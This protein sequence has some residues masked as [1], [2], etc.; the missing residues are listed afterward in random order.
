MKLSK[1]FENIWMPFTAWED[2]LNYPPLIIERAKGI[3]IYDSQSHSYIDGIGSWWTKI[4]GHNHP[5]ITDAV[6]N[7][8]SKLEHV[9]MAGCISD[10]TLKLGELLKQ[11]LPKELTKIFFSDDGSTAVEVALK[12]AL[13][14]H[15]LNGEK[16]KKKFIGL[17][18]GYHGDTLGAM[19]VGSIPKYHAIFHKSFKK[20]LFTDQIDCYRCKYGKKRN[21]CSAECL[22]SLEILLKKNQEEIAA[23]IFEPLLQG[24]CGMRVYPVGALEKIFYLCQ[25]YKVLT[26]ADEVATGFGRTGKMFACQYTQF[27]PDIM[28]IGKCLTSGYLPMAA[29]IV[30]EFIFDIFKGDFLSGRTFEHGHTF[31]GN[32]LASAA[33]I[34]TIELIKKYKIPQSLASLSLKLSELLNEFYR[35]PQVGEVRTLG[36]MGA[37]E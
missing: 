9:M 8:L 6:K 4:F 25:K 33:A 10:T 32:P 31:T 23:V 28:C 35:Y 36:M 13:Q 29:T 30:K 18:G 37:I 27:T 3:Y 20:A 26:I 24:A 19:S 7:Q 22:D 1:K 21:C 17:G 15:L 34:A 2:H 11:I 14:F 5:Y 16:K 12:I